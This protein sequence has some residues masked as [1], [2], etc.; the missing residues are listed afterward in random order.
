MLLLTGLRLNEAAQ[1]YLPLDAIEREAEHVLQEG[2]PWSTVRTAGHATMRSVRTADLTHAVPLDGPVIARKQRRWLCP[3]V[4]I[5]CARQRIA[6]ALGMS[7]RQAALVL[8]ARL[9]RYRE[10]AWRRDRIEALC[11]PRHRGTIFQTSMR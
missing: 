2:H 9:A 1:L 3:S 11:P 4:I 6:T 8:H 5:F 7:D 10:G